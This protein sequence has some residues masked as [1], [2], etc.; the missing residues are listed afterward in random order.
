[1]TNRDAPVP[2]SPRCERAFYRRRVRLEDVDGLRR[3]L[4][5]GGS[6]TR[7]DTERLL[8]ACQSLLEERAAIAGVLDK[9]GPSFRETRTAL[10][11]LAR[12]VAR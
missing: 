9:L 6:L 8:D 1:L 11:E 4:A 7:G 12:L 3:S 2:D 5:I 10:N